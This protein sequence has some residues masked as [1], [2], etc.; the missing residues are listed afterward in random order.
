MHPGLMV[1]TPRTLLLLLW[2]MWLTKAIAATPRN[3][4]TYGPAIT[5]DPF[6]ALSTES[7]FL[8]LEYELRQIS[9]LHLSINKLRLSKIVEVFPARRKSQCR[10][11]HQKNYNDPQAVY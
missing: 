10:I 6:A 8:L 3:K 9:D 4:S 5:V 11:G 2:L 7:V 1:K